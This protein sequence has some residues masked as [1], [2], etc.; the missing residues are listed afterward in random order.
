MV[1]SMSNIIELK[2]SQLIRDLD[3]G[4]S[5]FKA[6]DSDGMGS[7]QE[8]YGMQPWEVERIFRHPKLKDQQTRPFRFRIIDDSTDTTDQSVF[9]QEIAAPV[10]LGEVLRD[11]PPELEERRTGALVEG[12]VVPDFATLL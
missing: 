4:L 7:I 3:M 8:K 2:I 11:F 9:A 12:P 1:T 10:H 5:R 6:Q